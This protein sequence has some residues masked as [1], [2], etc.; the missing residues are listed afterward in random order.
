MKFMLD[1]N[2][3]IYFIKN[4]PP[5]VAARVNALNADAT[6]CMSFITYAELLK[7]A[8]RSTRKVE[9]L[10]RLAS[11][12]RQIPVLFGT[13]PSLCAH[14]AHHATQLQL[15]GTPIGGNDLWI[16]SHALAE[17]MI[18]VTNNTDEFARIEGLRVENWAN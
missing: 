10:R 16:A 4:K 13:S 5:A 18:L 6:L 9:V 12:T 1:T 14:Y 8:E 3:V 17:G 11:L 15:A 2:I 7:G